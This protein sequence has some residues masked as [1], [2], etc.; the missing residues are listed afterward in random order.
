[1]RPL[2]YDKARNYTDYFDKHDNLTIN[3]Q[4]S[5]YTE[6]VGSGVINEKIRFLSDM[7]W[8]LE[9]KFDYEKKDDR[10]CLIMP[11]VKDISI[12]GTRIDSFDITDYIVDGENTIRATASSSFRGDVG[13][14]R[15]HEGVVYS[16]HLK[17][18]KEGNVWRIGVHI[19]YESFR[20]QTLKASVELLGNSVETQFSFDKGRQEKVMEL[21]IDEDKVELWNVIG[22]GRQML[23]TA[24]LKLGEA[25]LERKVAFRTIEFTPSC[26]LI[27]NGRQIFYRGAVWPVSL[28]PDR[29]RYEEL[30][31]AAARG[32]MN[33]LLIEKG[34]ETHT[35][36]NIADRMGILVLHETDNPGYSFH[37]S[38]ISGRIDE[39]IFD[40]GSGKFRDYY[41][42]IRSAA[43][44]ER[45][46]LRTRTDN[47]HDGVLY[48]NLLSTVSENG[49]W[50]AGHFA[51]RRFF[52]DLVPVMYVE[53]DRLLVFA[54]ND[55]DRDEEVDLSVKFNEYGGNK[56]KRRMFFQV[57][58]HHTAMK[59]GEIDISHVDRSKEFVYVKLRTKDIHREFTLLLEDDFR[60]C[61]L[62]DP[63]VEFE[64][65]MIN[66]RSFEV[67]LKCSKPAFGVSL[68]S[69]GIEGTFSDGFF[70]I[71]PSS[72]KSVVFSSH[73]DLT[74]REFENSLRIESL[75]TSIY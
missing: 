69:D 33:L 42:E 46:V 34:H 66:P 30:L 70:E 43:L 17:P 36:Y 25:E 74:L 7:D 57:I 73:R 48:N 51:A 62:E 24:I 75:F 4:N 56:K 5:I 35:F 22:E 61:R 72:E 37:P 54:S 52:A 53:D 64:A 67:H 63:R 20:S 26:S 41:E 10:C 60:N 16:A 19:D 9:R 2:D 71:R 15:S 59:V 55:T 50:N 65:R 27:V 38:Y 44:L 49:E 18:H 23:Y 40:A 14:C 6:L 1:M 21:V 12:N 58:P 13:I 45:W 39:D 8:V 68:F 47:S 32:Y 28:Y 11:G 3:T 31:G 29:R